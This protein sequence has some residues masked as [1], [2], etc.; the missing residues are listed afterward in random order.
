MPPSQYRKLAAELATNPR[1]R[2]P[3]GQA[4]AKAARAKRRAR[5][6]PP[7]AK[8]PKPNGKPRPVRPPR[9]RRD[10]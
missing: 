6:Q 1:K 8:R 7:G 9:P 10:F 5:P 2:A 3:G 4:D